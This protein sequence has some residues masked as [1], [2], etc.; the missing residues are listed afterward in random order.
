MRVITIQHK[1]VLKTLYQ[2]GEYRVGAKVP[3]SNNLIKPYEFMMK[4]YNYK[5]RPIFMCPVGY[6]VNFGG[7]DTN[8]TYI[9]E[10]EIP[11]RYCK[12]QDYYGWSDFI[13]FTE[14]PYAYEP[15]H[16]CDTVEQ[17]GKYI[18]NMYKDGFACNKDTVY[19]VTTQFL[20]K[21]WVLKVVPISDTFIDRY[22]DNG[23][24]NVLRS[25]QSSNGGNQNGQ[26]RRV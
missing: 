14:M 3:V 26:K 13:Y 5:N 19:Q 8:D 20:R 23:G 7:A 1:N 11:D 17:F 10:L 16:G 18:L 22:V 9:V 2:T 4:H 12:I 25:I 24:I 21:N 6:C 15:F